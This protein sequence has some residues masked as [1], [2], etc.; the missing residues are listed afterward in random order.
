MARN[1]KTEVATIRLPYAWSPRPYQRGLWSYLEQGGRRAVEVAHR[2]W[3]K[4][5]VALH[6]TAVAA[7]QRVGAYWHMLPEAAQARKAI[8]DAVNP[9]TGKRRIDE[10]FPPVLRE[11]TREA[12]MF[13]RMDNGSTWQVVGSDNFNSLVGSPP[14]GLVASEHALAR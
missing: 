5:E 4:D 1:G 10:A 8:W 13:I 12:E 9:H 14:I 7:H 2:R 6:W 11:T 3:G